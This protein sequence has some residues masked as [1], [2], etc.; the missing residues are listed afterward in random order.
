MQF[1]I[2]SLN[3]G[4]ISEMASKSGPLKSAYSKLPV[5]TATL[6]KTGFTT[7]EQADLRYHGGEDKA[8]CVFSAH[9]FVQYTEF[10]NIAGMPVPAFGENF[11]IDRLDEAEIFIGDVFKSGHVE[12]QITQPRQPCSK[13]G[14]FHQNNKVIKFMADLGATG[15]YFRVLKAG[16][17]EQGNVFERVSSE[18]RH[19]LK[20][21]N[22]VM[23]RRI[24]CQDQ[25]KELI[26]NEYLSQAWKEEL[27][28]RLK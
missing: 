12:L 9:H 21:A 3:V 14:L 17:V 7:D 18:R 6:T 25:L 10:L 23:Y 8:V 4:E 19:S 15:F 24:K 5:A 20:F 28:A 26:D 22:D 16:D 13:T 11:T 1:K 2:L 27:S